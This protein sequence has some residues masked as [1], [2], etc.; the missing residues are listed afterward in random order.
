MRDPTRRFSDRVEFYHRFRPSYPPELLDLLAELGYLTGGC[1]VADLGSGTGK[2]TELF[3]Q[4]GHTVYAVEP[5]AEMRGAAEQLLQG[6][7]GFRSVDGR[8]E[9]TGLPD[10]AVDLA[11][12]GQAFH[13]FDLE[14][15]RAELRRIL[16]PPRRL[17]IVWNV[18]RVEATPFMIA[19]EALL[20]T[21]GTDY[22]AVAHRGLEPGELDLLF[23]ARGAELRTLPN[24]Q[25]LDRQGL[26]GRLLSAS[27]VPAPGQPGHDEMMRDLRALFREHEAGGRVTFQ[28]E[29]RAFLGTVRTER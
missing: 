15:T 13:W 10:G 4:R 18:R 21:H 27:Y 28:Y 14:P 5:N 3:L 17:A 9:S 19:Y 22:A 1:T 6:R 7:P 20:R 23:G 26:E 29:T 25:E 8:A 11:V 2:L 12:A 16:R 24:R